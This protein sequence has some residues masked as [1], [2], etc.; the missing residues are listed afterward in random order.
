MVK[1]PSDPVTPSSLNNAQL[2][3][4]N[5]VSVIKEHTEGPESEVL[6]MLGSS[7]NPEKTKFKMKFKEAASML[8]YREKSRLS[9]SGW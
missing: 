9:L 8:H 5:I 6:F 7:K 4:I 3:I 2:S 1:L